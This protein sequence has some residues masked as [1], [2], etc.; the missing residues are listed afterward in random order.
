[1]NGSRYEFM[2]ADTITAGAV[3]EP[4]ARTFFLQ[5]RAG[6]LQV[7]LLCEKEQVFLLARALEQL[8]AAV[9]GPWGDPGAPPD[10]ADLAL[11]APLEP[12]WRVGELGLEYDEAL[13]LVVIIAREFVERD[14]DAPEVE[15]ADD[16]TDDEDPLRGY[17]RF[18][19]T[20]AQVRAMIDH[21]NDVISAGRPR[22]PLC[23][24]PLPEE[25]ASHACPGTNGHRKH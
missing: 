21:A 17:A 8:L 9:P 25:G 20:R 24:A 7:T 1:M 16:D 5:A 13:D 18:G 2:P 10:A 22:C 14:P 23:A 6:E 12:V 11:R 3:G 4:G 15:D 19:V